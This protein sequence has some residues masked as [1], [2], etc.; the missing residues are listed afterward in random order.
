MTINH[1]SLDAPLL[2]AADEVELSR[3]IEA[4]VYAEY[5]LASG[6]T[7]PGLGHVAAAGQ[8][9]MTRLW[10]SNLRLVMVIAS[11][12]ARRHDLPVD[13]LF[14]DGCVGLAESILRF[15]WSRGFK[16]STYAHDQITH[17]VWAS[18]ARRAG[19][20][21]GPLHRL[22]VRHSLQAVQ[23]AQAVESAAQV[24][25]LEAARLAGFSTVEARLAQ[26][27]VSSLDDAALELPVVDS[28]FEAV[29]R[30]D[31][32]FL[33]LMGWTGDLLRARYGIGCRRI[34]RAAAAA[35]LGVP[36]STLARVEER[37]LRTARKL[38]EQ[39]SCRLPAVA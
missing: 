10:E 12:A 24:S 17:A 1:A 20:L 23:D 2:T 18:S 38:L 32:D 36:P 4:G 13:D 37:A 22:R 9:A 6:D 14:Q 7:R 34:S 33:H 16:F 30:G 25:S 29:D 3:A 27:T 26:V 5:L 28:A 19:L 8:R 15:D 39:D 11:R 31:L 21:D 35:R